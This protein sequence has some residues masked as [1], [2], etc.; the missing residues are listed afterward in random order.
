MK[1][2]LSLFLLGLVVCLSAASVMGAAIVE[3][4]KSD[5]VCY[6]EGTY[7]TFD[8]VHC[9]YNLVVNQ[10]SAAGTSNLKMIG[11]DEV[12]S[13]GTFVGTDYQFDGTLLGTYN[14]KIFANSNA[15]TQVMSVAYVGDGT[16]VEYCT[17]KYIIVAG[18]Q[19]TLHESCE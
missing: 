5:V 2:I 1:K 14:T 19:R 9:T 11:K 3:V 4:T 18:D 6:P 12:Y 15:H 10:V 16:A 17:A 7:D 8:V 13:G